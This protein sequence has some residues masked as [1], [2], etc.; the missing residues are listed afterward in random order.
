M[1][2]LVAC[3]GS[4]KGS[5]SHLIKIINNGTFEKS[6]LITNEFGRDKFSEKKC[7]LIVVDFNKS[8]YDVSNDIKS[9]LDGKII[10]TEV[11]F[12][13]LSGDGIMHMATLSALL[14]LGLG[15]RLIDLKNEEIKEL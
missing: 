8:V 14:R 4:G 7:E 1:T 2:Y 15:V 6:F 12:N 5:W 11:A 3:L 13:M 9:K 10:D